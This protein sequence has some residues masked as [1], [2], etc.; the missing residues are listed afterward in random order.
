MDSELLSA[1]SLRAASAHA[2]LLLPALS[3]PRAEQGLSPHNRDVCRASPATPAC[4]PHGRRLLTALLT[5]WP[6]LQGLR[7]LSQVTPSRAWGH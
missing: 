4:L 6:A 2:G 7:A 3:G 5:N 1:P